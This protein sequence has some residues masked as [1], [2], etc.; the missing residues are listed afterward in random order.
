MINFALF[1]TFVVSF[2]QKEW[3][4]RHGF[5]Q[6]FLT[7]WPLEW[8]SNPPPDRSIVCLNSNLLPQ[9]AVCSSLVIQLFEEC[10]P[11]SHFSVLNGFQV[12][13]N[14]DGHLVSF[15]QVAPKQ[16]RTDKHSSLRIKSALLLLEP[17]TRVPH[18]ECGLLSSRLP[19]SR[20]GQLKMPHT[21]LSCYFS[22]AFF[23]SQHFLTW[24]KPLTIFRSSKLILIVFVWFFDV[25]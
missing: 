4:Y 23:L 17:G 14:K 20:G 8:W 12:M 13:Q 6:M 19:P 16:V 18:S 7:F 2:L 24:C 3:F 21:K 5:C 15:F 22:V 11:C 9:A 1:C 25:K 10:P